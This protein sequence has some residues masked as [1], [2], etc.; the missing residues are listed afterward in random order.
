MSVAEIFRAQLASRGDSRFGENV[1][2]PFTIY[3]YMLPQ[4]LQTACAA[5]LDDTDGAVYNR[6][7]GGLQTKTSEENIALWRLTRTCA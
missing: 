5:W 4:A 7:V 3:L 1:T 6:L 2:L